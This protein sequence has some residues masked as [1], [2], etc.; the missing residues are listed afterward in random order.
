MYVRVGTT[1]NR[2]GGANK[3]LGAAVT[4]GPREPSTASESFP[5][6]GARQTTAQPTT[7]G[8]LLASS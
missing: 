8:L 1:A 7:A 6:W 3:C 4:C 2:P 5:A